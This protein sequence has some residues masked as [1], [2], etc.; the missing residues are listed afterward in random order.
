MTDDLKETLSPRPLLKNR[1]QLWMRI[2][3]K[4]S[5]KFNNQRQLSGIILFFN[6]EFSR[7]IRSII[8]D[9][10]PILLFTCKTGIKA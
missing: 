6:N 7:K 8:Q 2:R 9:K 1:H 3:I 4:T 10:S 5:C